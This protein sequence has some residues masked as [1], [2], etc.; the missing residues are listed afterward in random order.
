[1]YSELWND[2]SKLAS[3]DAKE[4]ASKVGFSDTTGFVRCVTA[5]EG[6]SKIERHMSR[7][8]ELKVAG[9]PTFFVNDVLYP[10]GT[11]IDV[12]VGAVRSALNRR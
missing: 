2:S 12:L 9:T 11:S 4:W 5:E 7:G 1:M 8:K 10:A 3:L 6:R